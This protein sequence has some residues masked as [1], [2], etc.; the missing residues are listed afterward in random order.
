MDLIK[1]IISPDLNSFLDLCG[2]V[3]CRRKLGFQADCVC[4]FEKLILHYLVLLGK[5]CALLQSQLRI[6]LI[7]RLL[8][9]LVKL[10]SLLSG[11]LIREHV[12]SQDSA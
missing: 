8:C 1:I 7:C 11:G 10:H 12:K 4:I 5:A 6:V 9:S 2:D 3:I